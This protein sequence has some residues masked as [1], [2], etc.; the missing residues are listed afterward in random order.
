[1]EMRNPINAKCYF[2]I[3]FGVLA[4][5]LTPYKPKPELYIIGDSTVKNGRGDGAG[6]QWGWG[7]LIGHYFDTTRIEVKNRA[8]G[9]TSSRTFVT[10]GGGMKF[11]ENSDREIM[12]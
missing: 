10:R 11:S 12:W 3:L 4:V 6:G 2:L 1:M 7:D 5:S 9:G 8:L